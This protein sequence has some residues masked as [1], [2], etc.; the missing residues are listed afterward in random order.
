MTNHLRS[1]SVDGASSSGTV[2]AASGSWVAMLCSSSSSMSLAR[3]PKDELH[4]EADEPRPQ[5]DDHDQADH[6]E[7]GGHPFV[8]ARPGDA[9]HL[10]DDGPEERLEIAPLPLP[11]ERSRFGRFGLR[12]SIVAAAVA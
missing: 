5:C 3:L 6:H 2:T 7:R 9:L 12:F 1:G 4:D 10:G 8:A 11:V